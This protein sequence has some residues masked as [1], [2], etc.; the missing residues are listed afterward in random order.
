MAILRVTDYKVTRGMERK[1]L[2]WLIAN[3]EL[4]QEEADGRQAAR[5]RINVAQAVKFGHGSDR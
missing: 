1:E 4:T 3:G 2:D 5:D